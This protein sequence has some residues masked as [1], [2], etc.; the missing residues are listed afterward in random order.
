M[1]DINNAV[2]VVTKANPSRGKGYEVAHFLQ[3][4]GG[5][6]SIADHDVFLPT[7]AKAQQWI[8]RSYPHAALI[9]VRRGRNGK[10]SALRFE[11]DGDEVASSFPDRRGR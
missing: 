1:H 11:C 7:L 3:R 10:V 6:R 2:I 9:S 5:L 4:R 8:L